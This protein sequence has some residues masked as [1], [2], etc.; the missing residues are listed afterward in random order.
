MNEEL[1]KQENNKPQRDEKG[2][3]LPGNTANPAGRPKGLSLTEVIKQRLKELSPDGKRSA[4]EWMADNIIQDALDHDNSMR[5][6][7]WN[8]LDGMPPQP[9]VGANDENWKP[10]QIIISNQDGTIPPSPEESV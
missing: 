7:L 3:L 2:R 4:L 5:K 10:I 6:L 9:L 8:Y 1:D